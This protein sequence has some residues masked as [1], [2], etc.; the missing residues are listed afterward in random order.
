VIRSAH[1]IRLHL[2]RDRH[3]RTANYFGSEGVNIS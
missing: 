3:Q 1:Q 2:A